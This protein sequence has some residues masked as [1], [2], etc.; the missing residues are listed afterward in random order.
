MRL[1]QNY[2]LYPAYKHD[3][4]RRLRREAGRFADLHRILLADRYS[5]A[6]L[7]KPC[8]DGEPDA[9]ITCG[10][11]EDLQQAWARENGLPADTAMEDILLAQIEAH[12]TDILYNLDPM[13]YGNAFLK[14]LPGCVRKTLAWRAAPSAG[15]DFEQHDL[16]LTS[17]DTM[18]RQYEALGMR[19]ARFHPAH[20]PEM[21]AYAANRDRPIDVAFAGGY[22][23][24][25]MRRA[26]VL[27]AVAALA[28]RFSIALHL[29]HSRMTRLAETPLGLVGPLRKYRRPRA[30]RA[31]M[32]PPVFGRDLYEAMGSAKIVLNGAIDM[33][34]DE[35]VNMRCWEAM[36]CGAL[37]LGE[38]GRYPDG[39]ADGRTIALFGSPDELGDRIAA[40]LADEP[41]RAARAQAGYAMISSLYSKEN[42]WADFQREVAAL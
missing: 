35:R 31:T 12:R 36:G 32:R 8:L 24:H 13:R 6:H 17:L 15:G 14:R 40:L 11:D 20:D 18:A 33:A 23:R 42:Q 41:A 30:I 3:R 5:A 1:F 26:K 39:M 19:T 21:D 37:M 25:H 4:L 27:E 2:G 7:L 29:D 16:L 10:D 38:A 9:F 34:G 22:S 28:D